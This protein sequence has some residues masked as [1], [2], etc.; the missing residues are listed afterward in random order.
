[1]GAI[2]WDAGRLSSKTFGPAQPFW[3]RSSAGEIAGEQTAM[4]LGH[5]R[6]IASALKSPDRND[7]HIRIGQLRRQLDLEPMFCLSK[8]QRLPLRANAQRSGFASD[9][10]AK[11]GESARTS[12]PHFAPP[13][14][15]SLDM[16][17][18]R[19]LAGRRGTQLIFS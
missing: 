5:S 18:S 16:N 6:K 19:F 7:G 10:V 13:V 3:E 15:D 12:S 8:F 17:S 1:M 11:P 2:I 4:M 14:I 9:S